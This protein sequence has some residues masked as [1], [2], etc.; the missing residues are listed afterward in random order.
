MCMYQ[1]IKMR[2]YSWN[3]NI[4]SEERVFFLAGHP[5]GWYELHL[6]E[7]IVGTLMLDTGAV[8]NTLTLI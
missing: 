6:G 3:I 8:S 1:N 7:A 4:I 2:K 5:S